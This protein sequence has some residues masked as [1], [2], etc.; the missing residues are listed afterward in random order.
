VKPKG[1]APFLYKAMGA[2]NNKASTTSF[3]TTNQI[4]N[5]TISMDEGVSTM[6]L[7]IKRDIVILAQS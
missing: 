2:N 6:E 7:K 3:Q 4:L 5:G 1:K